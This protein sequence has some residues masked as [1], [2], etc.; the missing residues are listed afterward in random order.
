M[1]SARDPRRRWTTFS[2][3]TTIVI[4]T[5]EEYVDRVMASR[6]AEKVW[7]PRLRNSGMVSQNHH[8]PESSTRRRT[9]GEPIKY[10]TG[11]YVDEPN[12]RLGPRRPHTPSEAQ[13]NFTD[14]PW[15][16]YD[17]KWISGMLQEIQKTPAQKAEDK[18]RALDIKE[19]DRVRLTFKKA[20]DASQI[21]GNVIGVKDKDG[22][23]QLR[24]EG[25][26]KTGGGAGGQYVWFV[27]AD[28]TVEVLHRAYR[29]TT[30]DEI[31]TQIMGYSRSGWESLTEGE[32]DRHRENYKSR[33][34][35]IKQILSAEE[36]QGVNP[37]DA[38]GG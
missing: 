12:I 37:V 18:V 25:F 35:R 28:Y 27:A 15:D 11:G 21:E 19:G 10:H 6:A 26:G 32:R 31:V 36:G 17:R 4:R 13:I 7:L 29:W 3:A 30:D 38:F 33:V 23:I 34:E 2:E 24:I 22:Q 14:T 9:M 1:R 16:A 8:T 20:P 5:F